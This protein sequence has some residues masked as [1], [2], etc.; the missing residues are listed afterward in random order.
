MLSIDKIAVL[1]ACDTVAQLRFI[2]DRRYMRSILKQLLLLNRPVAQLLHCSS[3]SSPARA[4]AW[5]SE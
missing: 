5:Y 3:H 1:G 2:A 4:A